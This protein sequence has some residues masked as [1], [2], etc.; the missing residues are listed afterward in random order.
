MNRIGLAIG[1]S[2][3]ALA[4]LATVSAPGHCRDY[5]DGRQCD[6]LG[7]VLIVV[8]CAAALGAA[9]LAL[10]GTVAAARRRR[11]RGR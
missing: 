5:T 2:L 10:Y 6:V 7:Y 8:A 3:L 11:A 1:L 9:L 4:V